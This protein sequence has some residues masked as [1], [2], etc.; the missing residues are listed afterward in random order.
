MY[1]C[2]TIK[3]CAISGVMKE[4]YAELICYYDRF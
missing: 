1:K 3:K 4:D 2:A